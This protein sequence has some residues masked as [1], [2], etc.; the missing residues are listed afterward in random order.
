M[1]AGMAEMTNQQVQ[2]LTWLITTASDKCQ[3][4]EEVRALNEEIRKHSDGL[5]DAAKSFPEETAKSEG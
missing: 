3:T 2:F 4:I 1:E 5:I